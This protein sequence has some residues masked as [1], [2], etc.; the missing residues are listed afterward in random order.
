LVVV[1]EL[2]TATA[3]GTPAD[4]IGEDVGRKAYSD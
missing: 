3:V 2:E 1:V 4:T